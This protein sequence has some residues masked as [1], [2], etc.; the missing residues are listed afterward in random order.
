MS[1]TVLLIKIIYYKFVIKC[2][3]VNFNYL[4]FSFVSV[5]RGIG[6]QGYIYCYFSEV[7]KVVSHFE[8]KYLTL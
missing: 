6:V 5:I 7:W 8:I 2:H 1:I 4:P 3:Y